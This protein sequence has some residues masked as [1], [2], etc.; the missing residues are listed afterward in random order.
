MTSNG[1]RPRTHRLGRVGTRRDARD[2][3]A[4]G[5][6]DA[7][8]VRGRATRRPLT[9]FRGGG[10][11]PLT[12]GAAEYKMMMRSTRK[13][14]LMPR[15]NHARKPSGGS[16]ISPDCLSA[17]CPAATRGLS[18]LGHSSV[19]RSKGRLTNP[20][21]PRPEERRGRHVTQPPR[22]PQIV[23]GLRPDPDLWAPRGTARLMPPPRA[24]VS[25]QRIPGF[26]EHAGRQDGKF[27]KGSKMGSPSRAVFGAPAA[28]KCYLSAHVPRFE[29]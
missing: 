8:S 3:R 28:P 19:G 11:F 24:L 9:F 23:G 18:F 25:P 2:Q 10:I 17:T 14:G 29:R 20:G 6:Q 21:P 16:G 27:W 26:R 4:A 7:G 13:T 5:G 22:S 12:S 1:N 15:K